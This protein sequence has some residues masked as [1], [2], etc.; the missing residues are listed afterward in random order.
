MAG[1]LLVGVDKSK[2]VTCLLH[3]FHHVS[4]SSLPFFMVVGKWTKCCVLSAFSV[5][6]IV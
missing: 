4:F 6:F 1:A 5:V 2:Q 3:T